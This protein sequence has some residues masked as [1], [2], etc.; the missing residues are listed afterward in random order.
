MSLDKNFRHKRL[1]KGSNLTVREFLELAAES[2]NFWMSLKTEFKYDHSEFEES[3][4]FDNNG[5]LIV[6]KCEIYH[7]LKCEDGKYTIKLTNE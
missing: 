6:P 4:F 7:I 3:L 5:K 2:H 1:Y